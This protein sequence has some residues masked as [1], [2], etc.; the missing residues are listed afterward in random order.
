MLEWINMRPFQMVLFFITISALIIFVSLN[1][2]NHKKLF[3]LSV[4]YIPLSF[5]TSS[6]NIS[7]YMIICL[8]IL[9]LLTKQQED[10]PAWNVGTDGIIA[11]FL[12]FFST[13]SVFT[14]DLSSLFISTAGHLKLSPKYRY[15][16]TMLSNVVLYLLCKKYIRSK[17]DISQ[18]LKY[19]IIS[20]A[21]AS[22]AAYLQIF[23]KGMFV[24]KYI[25]VSDDPDWSTRVAGTMT[26]YETFAQ[27]TFV[28][29]CLS[30]L[31][32]KLSNK[33]REKVFY[34]ILIVHFA[35]MLVSTQTRGIFV[36]SAIASLY[37]VLLLAFSFNIKQSVK[38][39]GI[40]VGALIIVVTLIFVI[41]NLR[42]ESAFISRFKQ[43]ST[44]DIKKGRLDTRTNAIEQ[45]IQK[46][47]Q[48]T[49]AQKVFGAGYKFL[50]KG[51]DDRRYL[52]WPHCLYLSY[53]LRNGFVGLALLVIFFAC[54][55][56]LSLK[57]VFS[58]KLLI[59]KDLFYISVTFHLILTTL[60]ISEAAHEFIRGD[61]PQNIF[62]LIFGTLAATFSLVK[63]D[64]RLPNENFLK[65]PVGT[66]IGQK[67]SIGISG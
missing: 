15:I 66:T 43:F 22:V 37:L 67:R 40:L 12:L 62:F 28:L 1:F 5:R 56:I 60:I 6:G 20:G 55:Y 16:I 44:I 41:D 4:F 46:F 19:I 23:N 26:E 7:M 45:G 54:L 11:L 33:F 31:L 57:G 59:D 51:E 39:S 32:L 38:L 34:G 8:F 63:A 47:G 18:L 58:R 14:T 27:Y 42:P 30:S 21:I 3:Y 29:L 50:F 65:N 25:V 13:V 64:L 52:G 24:F 49:F 53:L 2:T 10:L 17:K 36:A 48:M 61:R 35:I 9:I